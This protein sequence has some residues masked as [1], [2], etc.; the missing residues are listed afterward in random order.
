MY[1]CGVG[2]EWPGGQFLSLRV[3][4]KEPKKARPNFAALRVPN[5]SDAARAAAQLA[6][7]AQTVLADFPRTASEKLAAQKGIQNPRF[8]RR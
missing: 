1:S 7:R 5:F 4:R 3:Q 8:R 6:L 2:R